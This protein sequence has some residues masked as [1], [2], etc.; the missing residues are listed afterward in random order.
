[1]SAARVVLLGACLGLLGDVRGMAPRPA[2]RRPRPDTPPDAA[3]SPDRPLPN[4]AD[5]M[6]A[7]RSQL[8]AGQG[9]QRQRKRRMPS[10]RT[11]VDRIDSIDF[12]LRPPP[13]RPPQPATNTLIAWMVLG[14]PTVRDQMSLEMGSRVGAAV[15]LLAKGERPDVVCFC[16]GKLDPIQTAA[17]RA[18]V[19]PVTSSQLAYSFFRN[20]AE[21]LGD[22]LEGVKFIVEPRACTRDGVLATTIALRQK[23]LA[24]DEQ[25]DKERQA[26][27]ARAQAAQARAQAPPPAYG[28]QIPYLGLPDERDEP[29]RVL[30]RLFST[31]HHLFR[32]QE[33]EALIP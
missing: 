19:P 26:Q 8:V 24:L 31:D 25:R 12:S 20:A 5:L 2:P 27:R 23:V 3:V 21:M 15:R 6:M 13:R 10:E 33:M 7:S 1:M 18:H 32:I 9:G 16:G 14:K 17:E 29:P 28:G 30:V 22:E 11:P 4:L